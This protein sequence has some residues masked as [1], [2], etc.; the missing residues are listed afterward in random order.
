MKQGP[1]QLRSSG[2]ERPVRRESRHPAAN[3]LG[4][5]CPPSS[6]ESPDRAPS[7]LGAVVARLVTD[8]GWERDVEV[9]GV[10]GRWAQIVG[11][12]LAEHARPETFDDGVL[13]VR[14]ASTSWA[15]E[16]RL[17]SGSLLAR[18]AEETGPDVR[19]E[20]RFLGPPAP[21]WRHGRRGVAGGRGPRDTYG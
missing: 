7:L 11:P 13:V 2:A 16:L 15:V 4:D 21:T 18:I 6:V 8:R 19:T 12:A 17:L 1:D 14:A 10:I 5:V 3:L 20:R 9:G